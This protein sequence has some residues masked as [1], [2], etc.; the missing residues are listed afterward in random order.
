MDELV[1]VQKQKD[2]S[3]VVNSSDLHD[4]LDVKTKYADW[5]KQMSECGFD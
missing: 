4:F 5:F 2:G 3:V 1:P